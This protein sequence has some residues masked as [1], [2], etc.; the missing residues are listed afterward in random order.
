[1]NEWKSDAFGKREIAI[2]VMMMMTI[3]IFCSDDGEEEEGR[4]W[5]KRE[6]M[7]DCDR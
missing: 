3:M 4:K 1:M 6:E 5:E 2:M 7:K